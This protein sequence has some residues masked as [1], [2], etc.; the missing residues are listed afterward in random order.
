[1]PYYT[2]CGVELKPNA[3]FCHKCGKMIVKEELGKKEP[4]E[5]G[6]VSP[7]LHA[8]R[9]MLG[10]GSTIVTINRLRKEEGLF[11]E[12]VQV[13]LESNDDE[14]RLRAANACMHNIWH[15]CCIPP[16][17]EK[18]QGLEAHEISLESVVEDED[19]KTQSFIHRGKKRR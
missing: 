19:T 1:M 18:S 5:S 3:R 15:A 13:L 10:P 12:V 16:C 7:A 9:T 2:N 14:A 4:R 11:E 17:T 8:L 6:V